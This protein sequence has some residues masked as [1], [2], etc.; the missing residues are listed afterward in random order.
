MAFG[1]AD[2]LLRTDRVP[3]NLLE[4]RLLRFE[5][6]GQ[7]HDRSAFVSRQHVLLGEWDPVLGASTPGTSGRV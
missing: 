2:R 5:P 4:R 3:D 6:E 1:H 7:A